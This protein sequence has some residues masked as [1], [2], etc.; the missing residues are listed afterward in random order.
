[1][2]RNGRCVFPACILRLIKVSRNRS[3]IVFPA[4]VSNACKVNNKRKS[5][6]RGQSILGHKTSEHKYQSIVEW[7]CNDYQRSD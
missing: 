7:F 5:D 4:S 2:I 6:G 3:V 1:M